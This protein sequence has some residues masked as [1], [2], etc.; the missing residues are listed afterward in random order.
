MKNYNRELLVLYKDEMYDENL[1]QREV[2]VLNRILVHAEKSDVFCTA[3][4][5][6]NR[7]Y[8]TNKNS[9]LMKVVNEPLLKPF[10]F[11]I[12]KN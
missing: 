4:E 6:I 5:L 2:E 11:L 8:I 1:L 10:Q 9:A 12:N 7:Y 3:H